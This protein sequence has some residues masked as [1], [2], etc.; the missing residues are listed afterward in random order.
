MEQNEQLHVHK[1]K[2]KRDADWQ[3]LLKK[4]KYI[5]HVCPTIIKTYSILYFVV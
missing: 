3:R 5:V 2:R 4:D 1:L